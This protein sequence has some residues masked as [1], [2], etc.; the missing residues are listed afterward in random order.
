MGVAIPKQV[1]LLYI[2]ASYKEQASRHCSSMDSVTCIQVPALTSFRDGSF[3]PQLVFSQV[4]II[5]ILALT[6]IVLMVQSWFSHLLNV[7][8]PGTGT[9]TMAINLSGEF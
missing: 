8:S 5:A 9:V 3:P 2:R 4:F 7:L 6:R 1:V